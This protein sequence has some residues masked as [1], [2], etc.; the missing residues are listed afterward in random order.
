MVAEIRQLFTPAKAA[1]PSL[2]G[3]LGFTTL[4]NGLSGLLWW[5]VSGKPWV[6]ALTISAQAGGPALVA[7]LGVVMRRPGWCAP[8]VGFDPRRVAVWAYFTGAL[9]AGV[10]LLLAQFGPGL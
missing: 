6:A 10:A 7:L 4:V 2:A 8:T 1:R 9:I 5:A 3:Q